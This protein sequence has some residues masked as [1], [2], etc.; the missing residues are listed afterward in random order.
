MS[1][2]EDLGL[3]FIGLRDGS[4]RAGP[5]Y[6][7]R[8]ALVQLGFEFEFEPSTRAGAEPDPTRARS[9]CGGKRVLGVRVC[10]G[11]GVHLQRRGS[12]GARGSGEARARGRRG[13]RQ[14]GPPCRRERR[15]GRAERAERDSWAGWTGL[16]GEKLGGEKK[17]RKKEGLGRLG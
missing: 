2:Q 7:G 8:R 17:R 13:P 10:S 15:G 6:P 16:R 1:S 11:G 9:G 12:S 14:V 4:R 3:L 5:G